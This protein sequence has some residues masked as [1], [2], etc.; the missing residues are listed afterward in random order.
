MK[1][2]VAPAAFGGIVAVLKMRANF[3]NFELTTRELLYTRQ[4]HMH[5]NWQKIE[6]GLYI[7]L[8]RRHEA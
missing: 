4:S 3:S 5:I 2:E 7:G 1:T 6:V 8:N